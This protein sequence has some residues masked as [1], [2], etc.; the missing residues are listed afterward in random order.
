MTLTDKIREIIYRAVKYP[1]DYYID[2][3]VSDM[4]K[5]FNATH[6]QD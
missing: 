6:P 1:K 4:E 2:E 5:L 3:A